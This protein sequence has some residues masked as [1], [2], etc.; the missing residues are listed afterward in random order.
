M[1]KY[2]HEVSALKSLNESL[3]LHH[4]SGAGVEA[5]PL[6]GGAAPAPAATSARGPAATGAS[7]GR[8]RECN[9]S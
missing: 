7:D 9:E 1:L 4:G 2:L 6:A 8:L 3:L 5:V